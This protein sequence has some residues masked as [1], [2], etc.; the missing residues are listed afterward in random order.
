[1]Y[2]QSKTV[3]CVTIMARVVKKQASSAALP[4]PHLHWNNCCTEVKEYEALICLRC[5]C[6]S[7]ALICLR[8]TCNRFYVG[9]LVWCLI[10]NMCKNYSSFVLSQSHC[11]L[12]VTNS[13]RVVFASLAVLLKRCNLAVT[14][15]KRRHR[16]FKNYIFGN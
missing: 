5:T 8:C 9:N 11:C 4:S 6:T 12:S 10:Y 3:A 15:Q 16:N 1:M 7:L 14:M 2:T 13:V